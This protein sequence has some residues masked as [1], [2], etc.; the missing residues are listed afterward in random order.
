[1]K[2]TF[3]IATVHDIGG[4]AGAVVTQANA[5]CA[6]HDVEILSVYRDGDAHHFPLD[7]RVS[8][9]DLV[10]LTDLGP[11]LEPLRGRPPLL[12][13]RN[14]DPGLDALADAGLEATLPGLDA[15][16]LVTVTPAMLA[17]A[18][19][20]APARTALVHQEHRS[21]HSRPNSRD[22]LLDHARR[23]DV[24]AVL[25]EPMA[26]WLTSELGALAP[27]VVVVPNALAPGFRPRS[28]LTEPV[29]IAAG[30]L[31]TEKQW[32]QLIAAF[33]SIS[34]RVPDW[35]LRIFG[36]GQARFDAMGL[37]RRLGLWDRVELPGPTTDLTSEWARASISALTSQPGE[38][39]PLVIQEAMAAGVP[40]VAYDM[41]TGP[42]DQIDHDVDGLLVAQG[43]QA[44]LA[45]ALLRLATEPSTRTRL[46]T[47]A[48]AKAA[49][50]DSTT[51]TS[52]WLEIYADAVR[53][54]GAAPLGRGRTAI[55]LASRAAAASGSGAKEPADQHVAP[56]GR[57]GVGVTPEQARHETLAA[58]VALARRV[59][60]E[61][62]VVPPHSDEQA[63]VVL[64]MEARAAFVSGLP[65]AGLP[66]YVSVHDPEHR[67]WPSRRGLPEDMVAPLVRARTGRLLLEPWPRL[68]ERGA[69]LG[70]G[71]G[72]AVEFWERGVDGDLHAPDRARLAT[73]VPSGAATAATRVHDVAVATIP[74]MTEPTPYECQ[75]PIDVVY[76]WV[77]G[78]DAGWNDAREARLAAASDA[79]MLTRASSG[80]ARYVDRGE[81]RYSLRGVHLFAPWV[82]RIHLVTAGQVP[83]WLDPA[84]PMLNVVDHRDLLPADALP[85]F[86]S[87]AIESVLHRIPGLAEHFLYFNDDFFIGA[88]SRPEQFFSAAGATAVFPS[89]MVVGLP[90]Q[91]VLPYAKAAANNRRLLLDAFGV[92]MVNTLIHAP[93][94]HRVSVLTEIAERFAPEVDATTRAPF[95]STTDVS[96]LSSLAQHYG[97]MTGTAYVG[98]LDYAFVDLAEAIVRRR[99]VDLL[100]RERDGFCLGDGHDFARDPAKVDE[101]VVDFL[102]TYFPIAAPWER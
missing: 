56:H 46:G 19:Q 74:L 102:E 69:L 18:T 35:R 50:W 96:M 43:S 76:T 67:G 9:R 39:F 31:A 24:V 100:K 82:R 48:L 85:T 27:E 16:V 75:F 88:P 34:E 33:A 40:V 30:R 5:L 32:P 70:R 60:P 65:H 87:H 29:I 45:A 61:W 66:S 81:L 92:T 72:V 36:E 21:S 14:A 86:N 13:P 41:P 3:L 37:T 89:A 84:H 8:V 94:A 1:M 20:L 4:T 57:E 38:G 63:T 93:Y 2:I 54:R 83:A 49:T 53:R 95:R 55:L 90:G 17:Y 62:F 73:S 79:T 26:H 7:P 77:D 11:D 12:V 97:L 71:C 80:R 10:D 25:T 98:S 64:P 58:A 59:A 52:R 28:L 51:I 78:H 68:A 91:D 23:A 6:H 99:L 22:L 101:M 42:R 15:D 47:A 44:G